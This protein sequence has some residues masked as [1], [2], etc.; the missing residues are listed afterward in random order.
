MKKLEHRFKMLSEISRAQHF[1][2]RQAVAE[3][4]PDVD[5]RAV[6]LRMWQVTGVETA[7]SY[8]KRLDTEAPLPEQVARSIVW[9]SDCMGEEA[10]VEPGENEAEA[11]V[12]HTACPW[13]KWHAR[14]DLIDEDRPGCDQWFESMMTTLNEKLGSN[15]SF[16]TLSTLPEGADSCLRRITQATTPQT[17]AK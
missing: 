14:C 15:L 10:R 13:Q 7:N 11:Y 12:R 6:V 17:A 9:S 2:W 4:C 5:T 16:E 3:L 8:A 1:A